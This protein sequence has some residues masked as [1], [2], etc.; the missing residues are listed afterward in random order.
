MARLRCETERTSITFAAR[1]FD[2]ILLPKLRKRTKLRIKTN[3]P[4]HQFLMLLSAYDGS[5]GRYGK[6]NRTN[7]TDYTRKFTRE[8]YSI[9]FLCISLSQVYLLY[10]FSPKARSVFEY[11]EFLPQ[12][13]DDIARIY[14]QYQGFIGEIL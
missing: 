1:V 14:R 5:G 8:I 3:I 4:L 13:I 10:D 2:V 11:L 12:T 6:V 9:A 7:G